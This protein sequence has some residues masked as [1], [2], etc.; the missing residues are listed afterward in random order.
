M[1]L[2]SH[3]VKVLVDSRKF[4]ACPMKK[5]L[6]GEPPSEIDADDLYEYIMRDSQLQSEVAKVA[7]KLFDPVCN[8]Y[9]HGARRLDLA[10]VVRTYLV[11]HG[12]EI[13]DHFNKNGGKKRFKIGL[14]NSQAVSYMVADY[15][16][17]PYVSAPPKVEIG[18]YDHL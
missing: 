11:D 8:P 14:K 12:R 3:I 16:E 15:Y 6:Y 18:K 1:E 17:S 4:I 13:E 10:L 7:V 9:L 5:F 2:L